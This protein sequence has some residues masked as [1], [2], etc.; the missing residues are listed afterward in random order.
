MFYEIY[1][2]KILGFGINVDNFI[3]DSS[4]A[5]YIYV[6]AYLFGWLVSTFD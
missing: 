5:L 3:S 1:I 6:H 4:C 2:F